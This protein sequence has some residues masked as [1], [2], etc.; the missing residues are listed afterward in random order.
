M[1]NIYTR[2]VFCTATEIATKCNSI[3]ETFLLFCTCVCVC[4]AVCGKQ[5]PAARYEE[6]KEE[7]EVTFDY[8]TW[9][10]ISAFFPSLSCSLLSWAQ[11]LT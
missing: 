9:K 2:L 8:C 6:P 3:A 10:S 4:N 11:M 7:E 5:K 1:F